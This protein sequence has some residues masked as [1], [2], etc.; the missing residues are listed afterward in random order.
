MDGQGF[1]AKWDEEQNK[2]NL[3]QPA[4]GEKHFFA[5]ELSEI[6]EKLTATLQSRS[7]DQ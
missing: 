3:L 7:T 6:E 2:I 5:D 1:L 4:E